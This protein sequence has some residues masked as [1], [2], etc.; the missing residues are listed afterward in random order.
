MSNEHACVPGGA[1]ATY[2]L[3]KV[4]MM[5]QCCGR[6]MNMDVAKANAGC[7]MNGVQLSTYA[8]YVYAWMHVH[9]MCMNERMSAV[10][11]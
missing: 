9:G 11:V 6:V 5:A 8:Q 10:C 7:C 1:E 3:Q 4:I 2:V